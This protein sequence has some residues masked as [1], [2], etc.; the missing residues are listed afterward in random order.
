MCK[1]HVWKLV[2]APVEISR[3]DRRVRGN[4]LA[5]HVVE[6]TP[7]S[8]GDATALLLH[9]FADAAAS[10][11]L[12][13]PALVGAGLRVIA[14][15][16]R[17]FGD[18][19]RAGDGGHYHFVDYVFDVADVVDAMVPPQ[20]PLFVA[21]HSMGGTVATLYA[22]TFPD[23]PAKLALLEGAGPPDNPHEVA[24]DRMRAWIDQSR[25]VRARGDRSMATLDEALDRL[26]GNHPRVAREV[27][28]TRLDALVRARGDGRFV[29]RR[30]PLHTTRS[31]TP[32][33]AA[34]WR[35]FAARVTCPVLSVSGGPFG[36]HAPDED[37]RLACFT[38]LERIEVS[39]AGHMM[40]WTKPR[41]LGDALV[42][43]W[44]R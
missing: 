7:A 24:P 41:E 43:F 14:P 27:L 35:A 15:D 1:R 13:A 2:S 9:G 11:D 44:R 38:R 5:H 21:G 26:A 36:W 34:S 17:G 22:G 3:F 6:W 8:P 32:F 12:V 30:D 10:W 29:W 33:F 28:A 23:R 19:P 4:A 20:A 25:G 16:L 40:H 31:P 18:A 39:D 42:A 37:Q